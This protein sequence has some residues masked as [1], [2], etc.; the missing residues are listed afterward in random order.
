MSDKDIKNIEQDGP[1]TMDK[2]TEVMMILGDKIGNQKHMSAIRDGFTTFVPFIIA[3]AMA[4]M[5]NSVFIDPNGLLAYLFGVE[6]GMAS[7][8][9]WAS[10]SMYLSP[11]FNG[12][13]DA[14]FSF[15]SLYIAFLLGYFLMGSYGGNQLFGGLIGLASFIALGPL[16]AGLAANALDGSW[17][18]QYFGTQGVLM[19]IIAGLT[20]PMLLNW[21]NGLDALRIKMPDGVPPAVANAFSSLFPMI[22]TLLT[23]ALVQP[24]WFAFAHNV[25]G[26]T[27]T[28]NNGVEKDVSQLFNAIN[29]FLFLPL[30]GMANSIWAIVII[31]GLT[32]VFW[33]F[34]VHGQ[35]VLSPFISTFWITA[36][37]ANVG[38]F[39]DAGS[40]ETLEFVDH[41]WYLA[42]QE[43]FLWTETTMGSFVLIG[44]GGATLALILAITIFSKDKA[45]R[46]I[47]KLG[48]PSGIFEINEPVIFG[49][50]IM[51]N[52]VYAIPFIIT[53][54]LLAAQTYF[55]TWLGVLSPV[56]IMVPWTTPPILISFLATLDPM[57]FIVAS[58]NFLVAFAV[59]TPFAIIDSRTQVKKSALAEGITEK[60]F[61]AKQKEEDRLEKIHAKAFKPVQVVEKEISKLDKKVE[62]IDERIEKLNTKSDIDNSGKVKI[63]KDL[64]E[65]DKQ[66]ILKQKENLENNELPKAQT[67]AEKIEQEL[68]AN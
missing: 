18:L 31:M 42:G 49:L 15:F 38:V 9:T 56:V 25:F 10:V 3:G 55:L 35:N 63:E 11:I 34:G 4:L 8:D 19:A 45:S 46:Q 44:G 43:L 29:T 65:K 66:E 5:M 27:I 52:P 7:Y 32:G 16:S 60:E 68:L 40:L 36:T 22:I 53:P 6:E 41:H 30:Q 26:D 21:L 24:L 37:V 28:M 23:V 51:L 62:K 54:P 1:S 33:F 2:I 67:E 57:A 13:F 39:S 59:Y 20:A 61:L 14:T 64:L 12:A 58:L 17:P 48:A 47:A 50:P